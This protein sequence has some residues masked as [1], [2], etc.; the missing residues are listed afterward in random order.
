MAVDLAAG[1]LVPV[2]ETFNPG[3]AEDVHALYVG[4]ARL[5]LRI[6]RFADFLTAHATVEE[7]PRRDRGRTIGASRGT[8]RQGIVRGRARRE[9]ARPGAALAAV[10]PYEC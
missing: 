8:V 10:A 3:D 4:H 7:G 5:A 9:G 1:R 6:R 2:P